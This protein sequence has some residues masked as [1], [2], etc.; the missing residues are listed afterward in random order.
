[1][2]YTYAKIHCNKLDASVNEY[3]YTHIHIYNDSTMDATNGMMT[4]KREIICKGKHFSISLAVNRKSI[5]MNACEK[6]NC[7]L[8]S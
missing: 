5:E 7:L 6:N 4:P 2:H 8:F 3:T 1:M